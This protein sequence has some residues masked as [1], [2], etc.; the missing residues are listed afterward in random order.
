MSIEITHPEK[1]TEAD[2]IDDN[3][4][5]LPHKITGVLPNFSSFP[6]QKILLPILIEKKTVPAETTEVTFS[7]LDGDTDKLYYITGDVLLD[8]PTSDIIMSLQPNS[9]DTRNHYQGVLLSWGTNQNPTKANLPS[10]EKGFRLSQTKSRDTTTFFNAY[11]YSKTGQNRRFTSSAC[12]Y[13]SVEVIVH[14]N[15]NQWL[16]T[17][18]NITELKILV[19]GGHFSGE[20]KLYKMFEVPLEELI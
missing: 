4:Y 14:I 15:A 10:F 3:D 13:T 12:S 7:D 20:I 6:G 18:D 19:T 8:Y 1:P 11:L 2:K 17:D 16:N 5:M 9:D